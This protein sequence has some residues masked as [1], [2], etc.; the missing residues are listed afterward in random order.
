MIDFSVVLFT[1]LVNCCFQVGLSGY[2]YNDI[3]DKHIYVRCYLQVTW[4]V[5]SCAQD[6]G[7][8]L[9]GY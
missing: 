1:A 8:R 7:V 4:K 6:K 5:M 2:L 3:A 9:V